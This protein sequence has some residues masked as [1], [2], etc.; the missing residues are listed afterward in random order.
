M[1][2]LD[3]IQTKG[4]E[5]VESGDFEEAAERRIQDT[6]LFRN[7]H[8]ALCMQIVRDHALMP[9]NHVDELTTCKRV[10]EHS[11]NILVK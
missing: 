6:Q 2:A 1:H 8:T 11:V 5:G 9:S 4:C 10:M 7:V 3:D